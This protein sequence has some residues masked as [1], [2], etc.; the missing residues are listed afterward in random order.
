MTVF[1]TASQGVMEDMAGTVWSNLQ[2]IFSF[3][4]STRS[5]A[6]ASVVECN[7]VD[8][9]EARDLRLASRDLH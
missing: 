8:L 9:P 4:T 3:W 2:S 1:P 5:L 6:L 7:E